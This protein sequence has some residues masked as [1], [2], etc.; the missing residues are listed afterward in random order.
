MCSCQ[1]VIEK[2][3]EDEIEDVVVS[4]HFVVFCVVFFISFISGGTRSRRSFMA[5]RKEVLDAFI[6]HI[7]I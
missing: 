5:F 1:I 7:K 6:I 4:F 3:D 2:Q